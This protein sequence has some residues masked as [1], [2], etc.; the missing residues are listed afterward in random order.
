MASAAGSRATR[1]ELPPGWERLERTIEEAAVI[2]ALWKRRALEAEDE[3]VRLRHSLEQLADDPD[4][5]GDAQAELRRLRAEN[6]ALRSRMTQA[7][8]RVSGVLRR[9]AA[10][11][12]EP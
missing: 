9:L 8:K 10:L 12:V 2:A 11:E 6:A 4:R 3:V 1:A 7:G 5:P